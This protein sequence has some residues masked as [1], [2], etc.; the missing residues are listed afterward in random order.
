M[1]EVTNEK[2]R[3]RVRQGDPFDFTRHFDVHKIGTVG[4]PAVLSKIIDTNTP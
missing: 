4:C 2:M 3:R 1:K